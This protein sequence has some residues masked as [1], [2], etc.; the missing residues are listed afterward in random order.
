MRGSEIETDMYRSRNMRQPFAKGFL[1]GGAIANVMESRAAR[2]PGA[3]GRRTTTPGR[4]SSIGDRDKKYP[5]PDG[6]YI[7]D[8]LSS[9]FTSGNATRDDAP[10]H[11]RIQQNVPLALAQMWEHMCPAQVYSVP[12]EVKDRMKN[13]EASEA[14]VDLESPRRTACSAGPSPR[15]AA[16]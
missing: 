1:V 11:I 12:D 9:V 5:K 3:T 8:K 16:G 10:N 6:K 7:F 14:T 13:G 15:R 2:L 4:R